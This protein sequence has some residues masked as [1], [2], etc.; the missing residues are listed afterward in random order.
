MTVST[1]SPAGRRRRRRSRP[2]LSSEAFTPYAALGQSNNDGLAPEESEEALASACM[3]DAGYP[4]SG[5]VPFG[6]R[7]GSA[8]LAFSQPWGAWGYLG[9]AEAQQYGFRTP[10]GSALT[11]L[12]IDTSG[13][14]TNP[15]TLPQAEQNAIAKCATIEQNFTNA[16]QNGAL[17]GIDTLSNDIYNEVEKDEAVSSA[18]GAWKDCMSRNGYGFSQP[19]DVFFSELQAMTGGKRQIDPSDPISTAANQ[20]QI[21]TAVTDA[22]CSLSTGLAGIYFAVQA[23]Y[24]QQIVS[25]NASAL[26]AAV[27]Q[28]RA[29]Y[30][31][32]LGKL[33]DLLKTAS[34]QPFGRRRRAS[35]RL[36]GGSEVVVTFGAVVGGVEGG[37]EVEG[38]GV[39]VSAY[40]DLVGGGAG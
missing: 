36:A 2:A 30:A 26:A 18:T 16:V 31:K 35:R 38:G 1:P 37:T 34:V 7:L 10:A 3:T 9:V 32:E 15:A 39:E 11:A 17:A 8:N 12:G 40:I 22:D 5:T 20:A 23:S 13:L 21:A 4:D 6:I 24:E 28:Y 29:A 25:A 33:P 27:R 19:G 14:G